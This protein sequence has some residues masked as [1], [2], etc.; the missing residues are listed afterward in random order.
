MNRVYYVIFTI[1]L[2]SCKSDTTVPKTAEVLENYYKDCGTEGNAKDANLKQLNQLKNRS[3]LPTEQ[4]IN[5][6]ISLEKILETGDDENRWNTSQAATI[7]GYIIDIKKG[8]VETCNCKMK[9]EQDRDTH[10]ELVLDPMHEGKTKR[11]VVEVTPRIREQ[12]KAQGINWSTRSL[13]DQFLGRWVKVT[14]WLLFDQEHADEAENT[15]PG[16]DRNWRAS[17]WEL[18]PVTSIELVNR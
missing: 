18:H 4:D 3:N 11:M 9:E 5:P 1:I 7:K 8:G 17:A 15:K 16:R 6:A 2:Y 10:I 14:G 12:M 13:R